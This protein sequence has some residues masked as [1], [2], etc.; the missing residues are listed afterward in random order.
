MLKQII[1]EL[2]LPDDKPIEACSHAAVGKGM[3][4]ELSKFENWF[5]KTDNSPLISSERAILK[6]YLA[7]KLL[8]ENLKDK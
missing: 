7:W 1:I 2:E 5:I 6:T 4:A 8:F 3:D